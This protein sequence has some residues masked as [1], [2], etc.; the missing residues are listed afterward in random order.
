MSDFSVH[1]RPNVKVGVLI[2]KRKRP[3]FIPEWGEL[4]EK[5]VR[6]QLKTA[7]FDIVIPEEKIVDGTSLMRVMK[8]CNDQGCQVYVAIHP[9]MADG[10]MSPV[11]AQMGKAPVVLWATPEK[12]EGDMV[13]ACSLVGAHTFGANLAQAGHPFELVY[14]A[15]GA[16]QTEC[17]LEQA[18]YRA[19][20]HSVMTGAYAGL[21]GY[22]APGYMD[23]HVDP[24]SMRT[25]NVELM[26]TSMQ[27]FIDG[28]HAVGDEDAKADLE[29]VKA[30]G[31]EVADG[32]TEE[33]LLLSSKYYIHMKAMMDG[34]PL[35]ALAVRD[36]P[37]LSAT[38]WPYMAM[39][40][41]AS[42]G[43]AIA[44]EGDTDAALAC[45]FGYS[46]GCGAPYIS[47]WL[48]HD[49]HHIT[50]WH[51]G[52]AP[53]QM[54]KGLDSD[55]PPSIGRHFNNQ[56]PAVIDATLKTGIPITL[57]RLWHL[58][59]KYLFTAIEGDT[60]EPKRHLKGTNGVGYFANVDIPSY[61]KRM[62]RKGFPHHP[63]IAEG[64]FKKHL[65]SLAE[66][67]GIEVVG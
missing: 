28:V 54:C 42:E 37:E 31:M 6:D 13:S 21:V 23:M 24:T 33:D 9:T 12:Q 18:I 22:H 45:L 49:E 63:V 27:E 25:L 32:V 10:R 19:Y 7:S 14:G 50:L 44:P 57:F 15:P 48:E 3:G 64:H 41:L 35:Q 40:R 16:P 65:V 59:G 11:L 52:A 67:M 39:A 38:Q 58:N 56:K 1:P 61:F 66:S 51:T 47:D 34:T 8:E 60:V 43:Y 4:V 46:A 53:L 30:M 26:H 55:R 29:Q 20:A 36:W 5:Q 2:L 17:D 62:L